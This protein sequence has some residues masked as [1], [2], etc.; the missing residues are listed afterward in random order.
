MEYKSC[1]LIKFNYK[2]TLKKFLKILPFLKQLKFVRQSLMEEM[3]MMCGI[4]K[5]YNYE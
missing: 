3:K 1:S 2:H 5:L 4:H